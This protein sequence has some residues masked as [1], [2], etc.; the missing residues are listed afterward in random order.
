MVVFSP[1]DYFYTSF[2]HQLNPDEDVDPESELDESELE[3]E[4]ASSSV[5]YRTCS[6]TPN[7]STVVSTTRRNGVGLTMHM[8]Y[9]R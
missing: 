3:S 1:C 2:K 7:Q 8:Q 9:C 4:A 6:G 5:V